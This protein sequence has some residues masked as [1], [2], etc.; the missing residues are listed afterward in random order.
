MLWPT[1]CARP[2]WAARL[3]RGSRPHPNCPFPPPCQPR[4]LFRMSA[5]DHVKI[6]GELLRP[7]ASCWPLTVEPLAVRTVSPIALQECVG[8][9]LYLRL[10]PRLLTLVV[11]SRYRPR[12]RHPLRPRGRGQ[13]VRQGS[14]RARHGGPNLR[15]RLALPLT[16]LSRA[17]V[18]AH[19]RRRDGTGVGR[20]NDRARRRLWAQ[21]PC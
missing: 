13:P 2:F 3:G 19:W 16:L 6:N 8:T 14:R 12:P 9:S 5:T 21:Q 4:S 11:E 17:E 1:L 18:A 15:L 10:A 7:A 20:R